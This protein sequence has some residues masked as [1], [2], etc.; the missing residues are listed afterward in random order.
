MVTG[1]L[2]VDM[3]CPCRP[4]V[5]Q[6]RSLPAHILFTTH[7]GGKMELSADSTNQEHRLADRE[8]F[9]SVMG[10]FAS[11]VTIITTRHEGIDYRLTPT[12]VSSL[13]LAPPM[14]RS[15]PHQT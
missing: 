2:T 5:G 6:H 7:S 12:P 8:R 11:G 4:W 13:P 3:E 15:C 9:R 1:S 10:H 14:L